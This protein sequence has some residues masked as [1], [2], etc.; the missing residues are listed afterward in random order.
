MYRP[1]NEAVAKLQILPLPLLAENYIYYVPLP[2]WDPLNSL[3]NMQ[4]AQSVLKKNK[5]FVKFRAEK[6]IL[7]RRGWTVA[8]PALQ[9]LH[10]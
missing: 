3:L 2:C 10:G 1:Q 5:K 6:N 9:S 4:T 7:K 8:S